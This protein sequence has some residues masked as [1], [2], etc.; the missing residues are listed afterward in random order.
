LRK[1]KGGSAIIEG[2][3]FKGRKMQHN[4]KRGIYESVRFPERGVTE[5]LAK[6]RKRQRKTTE[7]PGV[8]VRGRWEGDG[9]PTKIGRSALIGNSLKTTLKGG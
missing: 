7:K 1:R 9:K 4:A 3:T 8:R 5:I 6:A 2:R